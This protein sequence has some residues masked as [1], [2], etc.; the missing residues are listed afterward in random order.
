M[1]RI[2]ASIL[3]T[4]TETIGFSSHAGFG[5]HG[6]ILRKDIHDPQHEPADPVTTADGGVT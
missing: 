4:K 3:A 2:L 6:V 1:F 5:M